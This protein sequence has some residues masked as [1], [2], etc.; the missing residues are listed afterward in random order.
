VNNATALVL[1]AVTAVLMGAGDAL[2]CPVCGTAKA[3]NDWAFGLTT[4]LL[5]IA[6][7]LIFAGIVTFVVRA[8]RRARRAESVS[9]PD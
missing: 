7:P 1:V 9:T 4:V 6:P 8:H 2:A 3:P 5:S